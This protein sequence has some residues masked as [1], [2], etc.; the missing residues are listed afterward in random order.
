MMIE[1][2]YPTDLKGS[3]PTDLEREMS[4][5]AGIR[6]APSSLL[7]ANSPGMLILA[8]PRMIRFLD[9]VDASNLNVELPSTR[10][11]DVA[12]AVAAPG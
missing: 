7:L 4:A 10:N 5:L 1:V 9:F 6:E 8:F 2:S 12:G 11:L 3:Y